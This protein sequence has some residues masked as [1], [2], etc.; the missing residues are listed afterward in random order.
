M[1]GE[2]MEGTSMEKKYIAYI[3]VSTTEQ[4]VTRQAIEL[5]QRF[6]ISKTFEEKA[7]GK[8]MNRPELLKLLEYVREGDIVVVE[9][10]SRISRSLNDLLHLLNQLKAKNVQLISLRE[11]FNSE[12]P[13]GKLM[14]VFIGALAQYEREIMLERQ[15]I[16]IQL[17]K[18]AGKYKGRKKIKLP[19]NFDACLIKYLNSNAHSTYTLKMFKN[20]TQLKQST[21]MTFVKLR[22]QA[23]LDK[24]K[25]ILQ[26]HQQQ[27]T[28]TTTNLIN[29]SNLINQ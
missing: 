5:N 10:Y 19:D 6:S 23:I 29:Q 21:L 2:N 13:T 25:A 18:D 26:Q 12:D 9:S 7:S 1:E 17:A 22:K 16:G 20:D 15:R 4:E 28:T 8:D 27:A 11:N 3:R 14:I 24:A